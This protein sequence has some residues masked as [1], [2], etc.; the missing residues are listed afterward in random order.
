M[1]SLAKKNGANARQKIKPGR[2]L[3]VTKLALHGKRF[4]ESRNFELGLDLAEKIARETAANDELATIRMNY[5]TIAQQLRGGP[6]LAL[7]VSK[8]GKVLYHSIDWFEV[9]LKDRT[10]LVAPTNYETDQ[11]AKLWLSKLE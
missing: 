9:Q 3:R 2:P 5:H 4:L 7:P 1:T 8:T 10:P 11:A 6:L